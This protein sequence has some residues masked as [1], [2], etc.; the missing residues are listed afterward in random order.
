MNIKNQTN[1]KRKNTSLEK[2]AVQ[3]SAERFSRTVFIASYGSATIVDGSL[4]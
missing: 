3:L 4:G 2:R 1:P